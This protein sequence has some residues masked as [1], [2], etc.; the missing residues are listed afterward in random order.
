MYSW[1]LIRSDE[2]SNWKN[3]HARF[4]GGVDD[5]HRIQAAI[6]YL[7]ENELYTVDDLA[8]RLEGIE[9]KS[10]DLR[11]KMKK[12]ETR[13]K[14]IAKIK[15]ARQT[16]EQL[17]EIHTTYAR[18]FFRKAKGGILGGTQRGIAEV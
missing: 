8:Q 10:A 12:A 6:S 15:E 17:H 1:W 9:K 2:R 4:Q 11:E 7:Q 16:V 3:T 5:W 13:I 14:N 18:T